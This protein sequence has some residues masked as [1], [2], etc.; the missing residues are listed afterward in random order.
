MQKHEYR[1]GRRQYIFS[2]Q[3]GRVYIVTR[4]RDGNVVGFFRDYMDGTII[5]RYQ[6]LQIAFQHLNL[7]GFK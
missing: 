5:T 6:T 7:L 3:D 4:N 1:E 2:H